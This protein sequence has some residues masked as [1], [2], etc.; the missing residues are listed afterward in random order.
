MYRAGFTLVLDVK[1]TVG[2]EDSKDSLGVSGVL[3]NCCIAR[4]VLQKYENVPVQNYA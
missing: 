2:S 3:W 1:V 4:R